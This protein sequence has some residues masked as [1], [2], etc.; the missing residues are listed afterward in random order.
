MADHL[1]LLQRTNLDGFPKAGELIEITGAHELEASDRAILNLL[2]QHAH[3]SGRLSDDRAEWEIPI[4]MLRA[5]R[6]KGNERVRDSLDRLMRVVVT[7]PLP[8]RKTGEARILKTHLLNFV[9]LSANEASESAT[10]RFGVPEKLRP[11]LAGSNRWG[12]IKAEIVCSMTSRYA[13][14]LYELVQLRANLDRCIEAFP[15]A[16]FRDLL[17]VPPGA[18]ERGNDFA[19]RVIEPA[20]LEVNG[21]SEM[22]V[23]VTLHR[24]SKFAPIESVTVAWWKKEGDEFRAVMQE[25]N[26][27]KIGRMA[28]LR[29]EAETAVA[30]AE[31]ADRG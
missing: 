2:F 29:G 1:T 14:A 31:I 11:V 10:V 5:S 22:A 4:A 24:R 12:R 17:G 26:R 8:D 9:D 21:L 19:K 3:D 20:I 15:L 28:R 27:S 23:D 25:R 13:I 18:Y 6:H 16:R 30:N 7:V